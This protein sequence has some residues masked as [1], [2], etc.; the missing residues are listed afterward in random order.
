MPNTH[1]T[2]TSLFSDIANAIR[3]KGGTSGTI[4]ADNFPTAI[5]NLPS[6]GGGATNLVHGTFTTSSTTGAAQTITIPYTGSGYPIAAVVWVSGGAYNIAVQGWYSIVQRYAIGMWSMTKSTTTSTPTYTTS[7][8]Q[9]QGNVI[10]KYKSSTSASTSYAQSGSTTAN[11]F[12]SSAATAS[13]ATAIRF[14]SRTAMS[15]FVASTSYGL[16]ANLAYEY[17]ILYSS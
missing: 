4:V 12:S 1:S 17:M 6:G 3:T 10:V 13:T 16:M 5:A 9:N 7:G 15:V 2:L 14:T 8:T 11:T